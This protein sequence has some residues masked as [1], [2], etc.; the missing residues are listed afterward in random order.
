MVCDVTILIQGCSGSKRFA[1]NIKAPSLSLRWLVIWFSTQALLKWISASAYFACNVQ[2]VTS[3]PTVSN[4][5]WWCKWIGL[6]EL[7]G[8]IGTCLTGSDLIRT[9]PCLPPLSCCDE[10]VPRACTCACINTSGTYTNAA[11][12]WRYRLRIR[13][14]LME[15]LIA[16][17]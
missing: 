1:I 4:M 12:L 16:K 13:I 9:S 5:S 2:F 10:C 15:K 8:F 3:V 17:K 7:N 11:S 6:I 14:S